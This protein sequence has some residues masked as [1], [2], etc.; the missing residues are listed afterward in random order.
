[1]VIVVH[2]RIRETTLCLVCAVALPAGSDELK[3]ACFRVENV[4]RSHHDQPQ[5]PLLGGQTGKTQQKTKRSKTTDNTI[6]ARKHHV[7]VNHHKIDGET[8]SASGGVH[9]KA[10]KNVRDQM[11][12]RGWATHFPHVTLNAKRCAAMEGTMFQDNKCEQSQCERVLKA[13]A[14]TDDSMERKM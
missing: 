12:W 9:Q 1:M 11:H 5:K 3:S 13:T 10:K 2:C 14:T 7:C 8:D 4:H 6:L